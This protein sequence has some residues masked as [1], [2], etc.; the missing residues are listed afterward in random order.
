MRV[1]GI[2]FKVVIQVVLIFGLETWGMTPHMCRVLGI[3]TEQ[4]GTL[5]NRK[6]SVVAL[7]WKL[8]VTPLGGGDG[9]VH[10]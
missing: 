7:G 6:T 3:F 5:S 1:S 2:L 10:R 9:G 8:G 4:G